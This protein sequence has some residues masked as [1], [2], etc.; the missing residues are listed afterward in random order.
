MQVGLA[1]MQPPPHVTAARQLAAVPAQHP[2]EPSG[3]Q[4]VVVFFGIIDILQVGLSRCQ[5]PLSMI[6]MGL[7]GMCAFVAIEVHASHAIHASF[8]GCCLHL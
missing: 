7:M 1:Q 4:D 6:V 5:W 2:D 3:E 8:A